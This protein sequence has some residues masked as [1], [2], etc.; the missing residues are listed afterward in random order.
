MKSPATQLAIALSI[1]LL[2][3]GGYGAWYSLVEEKSAIVA[4]LEGDIQTASDTMARN[5]SIR[6]Q[7]AEVAKDEAAVENYF[8]SESAVVTFIDDLE[9]RALEQGA[10]IKVL[11][12]AK[13]G[14][15]EQPKLLLAVSITGTFAAVMRATGVIEFAP[16]ALSVSDF[17]V[18]QD[19]QHVWNA[20]L[21][22]EVGS[23]TPT[24]N[25]L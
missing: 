19:T 12:V 11:S 3:V 6:S 2:S 25:T 16:Y 22:L 1:T 14:S 4:R 17:S 8:V 21:H 23:L 7:L 10:T 13:G 15:K 18:I 5:A 24:T 9:K 20:A